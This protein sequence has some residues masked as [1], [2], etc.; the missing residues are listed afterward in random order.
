MRRSA[1]PILLAAVLLA[2]CDGATPPGG[3]AT[4][5]ASDMAM[6]FRGERPCADCDGIEAWL[7]LEQEG[8]DQP[9]RLI[10]HYRGGGR[11]RRF[12]DEGEWLA[13]GDLLRLRS[14]NGGERVYARMADGMLQAR[15]A[16]GR[17][18]PAAAD[19]VMVPVIFDPAR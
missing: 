6:E 4:T 2:G 9:Y 19:D 14:R 16:R 10:E 15:D 11:D 1:F 7:R 17:P 8:R 12:D 5:G 3:A 18:L 13:E